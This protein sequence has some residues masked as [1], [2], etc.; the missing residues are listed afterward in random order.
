[1]KENYIC[2]DHKLTNMIGFRRTMNN[3]NSKFPYNSAFA[4]KRDSEYKYVDKD[5]PDANE[6]A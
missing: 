5:D 1:M 4:G 3:T 2:D 6:K